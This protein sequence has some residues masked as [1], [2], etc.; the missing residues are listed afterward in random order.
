[1]A[2][3]E[4]DSI[5]VHFRFRSVSTSSISKDPNNSQPT[6]APKLKGSHTSLLAHL[7]PAAGAPRP[8]TLPGFVSTA[9]PTNAHHARPEHAPSSPPRDTQTFRR[10]FRVHSPPKAGQRGRQTHSYPPSPRR[11]CSGSMS[12]PHT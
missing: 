2:E 3:I 8:G 1:M 5:G 9:P 11:I 6:P 10:Y 4:S 12:V 7:G